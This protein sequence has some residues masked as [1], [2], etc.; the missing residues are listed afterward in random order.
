MRVHRKAACLWLALLAAAPLCAELDQVKAEPNLE[1]RS[2]L[3][4]EHAEKVLKEAREAYNK[5]E[6]AEVEPL[7]T[8]MQNAVLLAESSL[9]ATGKNPRRNPK[10]FKRAE[11]DTRNL[12]KRLDAL[13]QE[14]S[15]SDR[16]PVEKVKVKVQ[17]VHDNLLSG[18]MEGRRK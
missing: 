3:A 9:E 6:T 16:S 1:K 11:I 10:Y 18:I 13:E 4:L 8:E 17:Q 7:L 2:R 5:G 15:V 14:M 12:L